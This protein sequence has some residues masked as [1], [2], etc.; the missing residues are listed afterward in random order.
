MVGHSLRRTIELASSCITGPLA[1]T[2]NK[3][4]HTH[5]H[6]HTHSVRGRKSSDAKLEWR[7]RNVYAECSRE[8]SRAVC[9]PLEESHLSRLHR[10][11][12]AR[13]SSIIV[14]IFMESHPNKKD[15][16]SKYPISRAPLRYPEGLPHMTHTNPSHSLG[17]LLC[18][19]D[20][21]TACTNLL[22][23]FACI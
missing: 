1:G 14:L 12:R 20:W 5:T 18:R 17:N 9:A 21:C 15:K 16:R 11:I 10:N 8:G 23:N 4:T 6:T 22:S 3:N 19:I 13:P 7:K 2:Q